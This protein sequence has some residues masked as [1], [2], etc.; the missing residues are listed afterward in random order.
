MQPPPTKQILYVDDEAQAL[1][2][3]GRLFGDRFHVLTATSVDEAL[4]LLEQKSA[5]IGV[6]VTDQRMPGKTGV[7]L[8]EHLRHRYPNI[9]RILTTAYSDLDAAIK[10]VNEGGAFR[11]ITKPWNEE[12]IVGAL[13]RGLDYHQALEDRDRLLREKLSVLHRLIIMDRVRGLATAATALEGRLNN[14]WGALVAY[15]Q[16]SPVQQRIRV[17][18]DEIA[19]LNMVAVARREAEAMVKTVQTILQDTVGS[20]TGNEPWLNLH[21]MLNGFAERS[22]PELQSEDIELQLSP[23]PEDLAIASDRGLFNRLLAILV[24]RVADLHEEPMKVAINLQDATADPLVLTIRGD[25]DKLSNGHVASLFSAAIPLQKWPLG[26]DMDLL[27]AFMIAYHL[28]GTL[29][30]ETKPPVGPG[31][32]VTLPRNGAAGSKSSPPEAWFDSVYD[33]ILAWEQEMSA[34]LDD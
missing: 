23:I 8:M 16:Q 4:A 19:S 34:D 9:V 22:R 1:K 12:E 27:S 5:E 33:A 7:T 17:Q 3:F 6:V 11:Y 25:F 26:L 30:I 32:R 14:A 13:L 24:R 10:S 28:G 21:E 15:M 31:F 2:Y 18:M 20:S 29:Q